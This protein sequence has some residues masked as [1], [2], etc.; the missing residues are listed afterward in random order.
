MRLALLSNGDFDRNLSMEEFECDCGEFGLDATTDQ[1]TNLHMEMGRGRKMDKFMDSP[2]FLRL[3]PYSLQSSYL[4]SVKTE[5]ASKNGN[6]VGDR[7]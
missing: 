1:A 3:Q 7:S 2:W 6:A 5:K 4:S